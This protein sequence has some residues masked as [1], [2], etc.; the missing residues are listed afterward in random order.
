MTKMFSKNASMLMIAS[1]ATVML[2]SVGLSEQ[3]FAHGG[4]VISFTLPNGEHRLITVIM[5][6]NDEPTRAQ[7][8][9][10][11]SGE[12][13]MELFISD[14]RTGLNLAE[15]DLKV[16][17]FYYKNDKKYNKAVEKGFEPLVEDADVSG[18]H[19]IQVIILLDKF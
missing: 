4:Q 1:V 2:L 15:S 7:E 11:W 16:D 5:G 3:A 8:S 13:P 9:G 17:K 18:V 19:G 14:T 12:H 6:H 10:K